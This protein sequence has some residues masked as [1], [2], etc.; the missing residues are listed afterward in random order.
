ME[1]LILHMVG[2]YVTQTHWMAQNKSRFTRVAIIH[3]AVYSLPFLLIGSLYAVLA[4]FLSHFLV[5]RF[6][7]ARYVVY[8]KNR[9]T[10]PR[11]TWQ[12][13]NA[14]GY[15]KDVP[16]WLSV[17]LLIAADNTIHLLCNYVAIKYL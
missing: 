8:A 11:L 15:H 6:G 2:D 3:A 17:G 10:D 1:Q 9:V 16:A 5:D 13:A 14:T 7:L 4:V 12:D